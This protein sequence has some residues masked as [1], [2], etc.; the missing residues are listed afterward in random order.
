[1]RLHAMMAV[2]Q[3]RFARRIRR[4]AEEAGLS[5]VQPKVLEYL[6][7]HDG[8]AQA[9]ICAAWDTDKATMSGIVAR[10]E[11]D[12]LV[13]CMRGVRDRRRTLVYLTPEG[14]E[15]AGL[16]RARFDAVERRAMR[17]LSEE[18][19]RAFLCT[20]RRICRNMEMG[21]EEEV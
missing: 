11:R 13:T 21:E 10:L 2:T 1:M 14:R 7:T 8:C 17:G 9:D 19:R 15:K 4:A 12:G 20:L 6:L 16:M 18:E 3:G 5:K